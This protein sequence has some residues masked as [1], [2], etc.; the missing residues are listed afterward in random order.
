MSMLSW[1]NFERFVKKARGKDVG[2]DD[3]EIDPIILEFIGRGAD[4][5]KAGI[6]TIWD[7]KKDNIAAA[8]KANMVEFLNSLELVNQELAGDAADKFTE[9]IIGKIESLL[10]EVFD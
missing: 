3:I 5:V 4:F 6:K 2:P 7:G 9:A 8:L 10:M 1:K